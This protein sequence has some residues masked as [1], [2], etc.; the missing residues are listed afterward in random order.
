MQANETFWSHI[1][2][3]WLHPGWL[4]LMVFGIGS[5]FFGN[6]GI[7]HF[8]EDSSS[9]KGGQESY[10]LTLS[11]HLT[12]F[13][14][15]FIWWIHYTNCAAADDYAY[16]N[17]NYTYSLPLYLVVEPFGL[18]RGSIASDYTV[19]GYHVHTYL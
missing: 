6:L 7:D 14:E 15:Q 11:S 10:D 18:C 13:I 19:D 2:T 16:Y 5:I 3:L 4:E 1:V 17:I 12:T 9:P 8:Y